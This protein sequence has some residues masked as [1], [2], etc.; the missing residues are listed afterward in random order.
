MDTLLKQK[1]FVITNKKP[2]DLNKEYVFEI[3]KEYYYY[4]SLA[5][6]INQKITK[7]TIK[8]TDCP[9]FIV[10]KD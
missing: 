6:Y 2:I 4:E 1:N 5:D 7:T 8:E 9:K 3:Q 10:Q